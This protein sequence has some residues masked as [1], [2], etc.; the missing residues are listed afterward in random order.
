MSSIPGSDRAV[1]DAGK[2]RDYCLDPNHPEGRHKARVF[3][4]ALGID[5]EDA[6]WLAAEILRRLPASEIVA[7]ETT[8]FGERYD[9]DMLVTK[10]IKAALV[11]TGWIV[12][13]RDGVPRLVTCFVR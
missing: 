1:V 3:R 8:P 7:S 11:R 9:V 13:S 12:R 10:G 4:S 5:Q 2:L 6:T